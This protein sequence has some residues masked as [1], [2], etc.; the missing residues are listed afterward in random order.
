MKK[1]STLNPILFTVLGLVVGFL[2]GMSINGFPPYDDELAGS[3]GKVNNQRNVRITEND[4]QLRN[5]LAEDTIKLLQYQRY[6]SYIYYKSL[7]SSTDIERVNS[8]IADN[9][10]FVKSLNQTQ[11]LEAYLIY[12]NAA[13]ADLLIALHALENPNMD[14]KVPIIQYLNNAQNVASRIQSNEEI[15]LTYMDGIETWLAAHPGQNDQDL[16]EA[17]DLLAFNVL[18]SATIAQDKPILKYIDNKKLYSNNQTLITILNDSVQKA[19]MM[20]FMALDNTGIENLNVQS[21][22]KIMKNVEQMNLFQNSFNN[23]MGII[24]MSGQESLGLVNDQ[25][26]LGLVNDQQTLGF[27]NQQTL[28]LVNDKQ[29]LGL[30]NDQQTLGAINNQQKLG[31]MSSESLNGVFIFD[32]Q[33]LGSIMN[34]IQV[35]NSEALGSVYFGN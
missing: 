13:R 5:D 29:K 19:E 31:L 16:R 3:I 17:H 15:F 6:L 20:A 4:I 28:N 11:T 24:L 1:N 18:Q 34:D 9:Q 8:L 35:I 10:E 30:V 32:Q 2:I 22:Q 21:S 27:F 12:L 33:S 25:Q 7:K 26:Q 14:N 23:A